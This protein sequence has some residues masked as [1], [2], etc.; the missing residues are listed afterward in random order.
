MKPGD[1]IIDHVGSKYKNLRIIHI[2]ELTDSIWLGDL[3][4]ALI[5]GK[6]RKA[7]CSQPRVES[8]MKLRKRISKNELSCAGF[9]LPAEWNWTDKDFKEKDLSL[10]RRERRN[11]DM[12]KARRDEDYKL[13]A[14]L[15][16]EYSV[17]EILCESKHIGWPL[18]RARELKL[19]SARDV[20]R[21]LN[22]YLVGLGNKNALIPTYASC[23]G[24]GSTKY[25]KPS[26]ESPAASHLR[27]FTDKSSRTRIALG[28]KKYKKKGVSVRVAHHRFLNEFYASEVRWVGHKMVVTLRPEAECPTIDQFKIWG[29]R[30]K[31]NLSA[32]EV[33]AGETL[34][35]N[36]TK[37]RAGLS[38][39]SVAAIGV[40]GQ[41]DSTPCNQ[42]L[43][44]ESSRL[45]VLSTPYK[46]E[47]I[48]P[49]IGYIFGVHVGF[50]HPCTTTNLLA[51]LNGASSKVEFCERFGV[52]IREEDWLSIN[53]R[54]LLADNGELKSQTGLI[55]VNEMESSI[56]FCESYFGERKAMIESS[57]RRG[58]V[59]NDHLIPGSSLG[60]MTE[61][62]EKAP[63]LDACY[64][65]HEY[66]PRLI[67]SILYRNNDEIVPIPLIEMRK[68]GIKP[69]RIEMIKWL[70]AKGYCASEPTDIDAL[71][72]RCLPR[73][74]AVIHADGVH[75]FDPTVA[76]PR[77]IPSLR[78]SSQWLYQ[79]GILGRAHRH[80]KRVEVHVNPS[81]LSQ[82]WMNTEGLQRLVLQSNDPYLHQ[83]T[84]YDWLVVSRDDKLVGS[85]SRRSDLEYHVS[86]VA[87]INHVEA[88][89]KKAK[90]EEVAALKAKP[91]KAATKV[92]KRQNTQDEMRAHGLFPKVNCKQPAQESEIEK[93]DTA[94]EALN[95]PRNPLREA[96]R[97]RRMGVNS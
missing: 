3:N 44:S 90:K 36:R 28:W 66:M 10:A 87:T 78:F 5:H 9:T 39:T 15:V 19:K 71:R 77:L 46:A 45:K 74:K 61:R 70:M 34:H 13:I 92:S 38:R 12:W 55:S 67:Q 84:L 42:N 88:E 1:I 33:N 80:A 32:R 53:F 40:L 31:E 21:A 75:L 2:D 58:Q 20:Y 86:R 49:Q 35:R 23:G 62:G 6:E 89:A 60:R 93:S 47:L 26:K 73:L 4:F 8:L 11:R 81:N 82:I 63:A 57:N 37:L 51:I 52:K 25:F 96:L 95:A 18:Q 29:P 76:N 16:K 83:V 22:K 91:T 94:T 14:P 50:E 69:V 56:E 30:H 59:H 68:D 97:K 64:T 24:V 65:F 7:Y 48:D 17:S 43:V 54:R 72:V 27:H 79:S 85:L 41:I